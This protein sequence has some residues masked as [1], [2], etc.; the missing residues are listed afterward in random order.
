MY[1]H[2]PDVEFRGGEEYVDELYYT[3]TRGGMKPSKKIEVKKINF[4]C[5]IFSAALRQ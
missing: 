4:Y 5:C 3:S 2:Y 1:L